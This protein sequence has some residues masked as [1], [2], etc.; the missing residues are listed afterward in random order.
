MAPNNPTPDTEKT[1][2]GIPPLPD[3]RCPIEEV[4]LV[5]PKT[6][7]PSLPFM[8]ETLMTKEYSFVG[9]RFTLNPGPLN[10]K[11]YVIIAIFANCGVSSSSGS[12]EVYFIGAITIMKSYYKQSLSFLLA[13][14]IFISP[15]VI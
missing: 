5:V 4:A 12:G 13:L 1:S 15:P 6:D 14:F 9:W 7:D 3:D 2:N 8:A 10:M 11:E